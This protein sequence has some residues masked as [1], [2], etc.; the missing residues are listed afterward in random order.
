MYHRQWFHFTALRRGQAIFLNVHSACRFPVEATHRVFDEES[1]NGE[2]GARRSQA[3]EVSTEKIGGSP[4]LMQDHVSP[5]F[6]LIYSWP[7][8]VPK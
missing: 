2:G 4:S 8:V 1:L 7:V 6:L 5:P 3:R